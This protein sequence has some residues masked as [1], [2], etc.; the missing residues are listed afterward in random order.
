MSRTALVLCGDPG[1]P[2]YGPSGASAHLRGTCQGLMSLGWQVHVAVSSLSDHRGRVS[3]SLSCS[4]TTLPYTKP[5]GWG[6]F[7][8]RS[9][10]R[11]GRRLAEKARAAMRHSPDLIWERY[12]LF[13]DGGVR[14]AAQQ[15]TP[16]HLL[17]VNAPLSIERVK[18]NTI[19]D[20]RFSRRMERRILRSATRIVTVSS[21]LKS[22]V[23]NEHG[24][25]PERVYHVPN[26]SHLQPTNH[27]D[28]A[29][30]GLNLQGLVVGFVG[31]MRPWHGLNHL[32]ALADALPQATFVLIGQGPEAPPVHPRI[33]PIG[34]VEPDHL[35]EVLSAMDVAIAP[36]PLNA[37]PWYCPLKILDALAMGIPVVATDIADCT[38]LIGNQGHTLQTLEPS[39]WAH[40]IR[41]QHQRTLRPQP[42]PWSTVVQESLA[43]LACQPTNED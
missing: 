36:Y 24:C 2:L 19:R 4:V 26:G 31:S 23:T 27:R 11:H 10:L 21:W 33:R 30:E 22:W 28:R 43:G 7:R 18:S 5:K 35:A 39:A 32:R 9:E 14:L 20:P 15:T 13:C 1:V 40:A 42:R 12:S 6:L 34:R 37:A 38:A 41:E 8:D 29:R 3:S 17:E 25:A 16:L